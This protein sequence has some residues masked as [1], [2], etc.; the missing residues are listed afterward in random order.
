VTIVVRCLF[1][2][3]ALTVTAAV[4]LTLRIVRPS[5]GWEPEARVAVRRSGAAVV[6]GLVLLM[7]QL[8]RFGKPSGYD[9][10]LVLIALF[11]WVLG[12]ILLL[13][14]FERCR[15][16]RPPPSLQVT[17]WAH[18]AAWALSSVWALYLAMLA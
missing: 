7:H 9:T 5:R 3:W 8:A 6:P 2:L 11:W 13:S 16:V 18:A 14:S 10:A 1:A 15:S 4:V 17:R 12:P